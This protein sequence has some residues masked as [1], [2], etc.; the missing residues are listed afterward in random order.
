M[1]NQWKSG[2]GRAGATSVGGWCSWLVCSCFILNQIMHVWC[3]AEEQEASARKRIRLLGKAFVAR[4]QTFE[5]FRRGAGTGLGEFEQAD[6][7]RGGL[8]A[9][10]RMHRYVV[11]C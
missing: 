7:A 11:G 6:V 2:S 10:S 3:S 8:E 4:K 9:T 5:H 1:I